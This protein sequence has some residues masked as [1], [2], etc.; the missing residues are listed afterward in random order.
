MDMTGTLKMA[1]AL[2]K[3]TALTALSK[4]YELKKIEAFFH[5][6]ESENAFWSM[7]ITSEDFEKLKGA[8]KNSSF[9]VPC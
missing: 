3:H 2:S 5:T 9:Y 6:A 4:Y 8:S 7:G 1:K